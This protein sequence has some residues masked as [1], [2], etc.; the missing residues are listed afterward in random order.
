MKYMITYQDA[1]EI[2]KKYDNFNFSEHLFSIDEYKISTFNYFLCGYNHFANPLENKPNIHAFDM[3]GVTFVFN[4]DGTLWKRFLML[5]KFFNLNQIDE[6]QY[7]NIKN[8]KIKHIST[9][10]DGSLIAFMILPNGKLFSK[11]IGGFANDQSKISMTLL[12]KSEENA[13]WVKKII[14]EGFT[15]LFE[16]VSWENRIVLKYSNAEIRF[17]GLRSNINGDFIPASEVKEI[18]NSIYF[19]KS[20]ISTLDELI[21]RSKVEENKEGWVIM[22]EDRMLL[23]VKTNWYFR[24]HNLRTE[25]IFREDFVI[26]NYYEETLDD[27]VSQ[28]NKDIDSDAF[29][30]I[31]KVTTAVSNYSNHIEYCVNILYEISKNYKEWN[32]FAKQ[33]HK[34]PYFDFVKFYENKDYYKEKKINYILKKT[35]RLNNA[36]EIVEKWVKII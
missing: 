30:F 1:L 25:N 6:T 22:L 15:P 11:T 13:I 28:L 29:E 26:K 20:E 35:Y 3:R 14:N 5:P 36:R 16:Y 19:I 8:K 12:Y 32:D 9:K 10:E 23:K 27:I 21:E 31:N 34:E 17:I 24:S 7:S 33:Y 2:C 18:P 4:L